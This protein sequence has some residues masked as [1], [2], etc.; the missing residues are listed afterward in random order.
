MGTQQGPSSARSS[1]VEQISVVS[2]T[3]GKPWFKFFPS[4]TLSVTLTK[5]LNLSDLPF[6]VCKMGIIAR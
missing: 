4:L 6:S 3:S 2:L 1:T 5:S